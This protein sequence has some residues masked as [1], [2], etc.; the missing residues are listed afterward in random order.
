MKNHW[1][2]AI[3]LLS[4]PA[5]Q[6]PAADVLRFD[7]GTDRSELREGFTRVTARSVYDKAAGF[8]WKSA[9]GLQEQ[10]RHYDREWQ[11]DESRGRQ[12][13]PQIYT[14]EITCD[15]IVGRAANSFLIDLPPGDYTAW[16]LSGLSAGSSREYHDF[17]V[18]VDC[19]GRSQRPGQ[20]DGEN[21][22][23][24]KILGPYI[25]EKRTFQVSPQDG[26][27]SIEFQP[28]TDWM[29][30]AVIVFPNAQAEHV[31][32]DFLDAL[33][34]EIDF[35]PPDVAAQWHETE[36]V[37]PR[38]LPEF[39]PADRRRGYALFARHWSEVIYPGTVPRQSELDPR[40][41]AFA[42]LGEYE[43]VTF[44]VHPLEDLSGVTVTAGEL[45]SGDA[46]IP[47]QSVD[48][49]SVR[50]MLV[51]PNYSTYFSYHVAPDVLE[52]R[53]RQDVKQGRNQ[54][55]WITV[56]VPDDAAPGVYEGKL[57]LSAAGREPAEVPLS[58]RVLPVRLR[59]NP[60]HIYG[61]YY[62]D[63]LSNL[64]E[65][66]TPQANEY[67][68]RKAELERRDMVEHGMTCH[69]SGISG[70][71]RDADGRWTM[72]GE[73]TERRIALDRRFGLADQPLV[74]S[75][76]VGTWYARLVDKQGLGSHLRLV[77]GDVPQS[78][79]DEVTGMV[80]AIEK[81][82]SRR[83]WPEFL[84]YPIDEPATDENPVRF[85]TG[86]LKAV[87]RVP[88]VRTYVTADPSH[89]AF[90]PMW[91]WV[92]VWCCQPFVF[93]VE[94]IRRLSREKNI[95][96]WCY[97][98]H[99]SGEN[100]HTPVRGVRMTWG[101]G[102]WKSGFKTLIPW[103]YQSSGG[104]PWNYLDGTSM[105]FFNRSTPDGEPIPVAMWEA[106]REGIDDGRYLYTLQQLVAEAKAAGGPAAE[107]AEAARREL[108]F[109]WNAIEV[110]EK[111]K[112][113]GLWSG[114]DFDAYRWL[115]ASKILELEAALS[116]GKDR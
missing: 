62:R 2:P 19:P 104:D 11:Y 75:F 58:I 21:R 33:E 74:V 107:K 57:T 4:L 70:L 80:E 1:L 53:D 16:L 37:D 56:K 108:D 91:P 83:G 68:R 73:E 20:L 89:E 102:F 50:Y 82:R 105:D 43:P 112:Y 110:Q 106:Y 5:A 67:F 48:V 64:D 59:K 98:N 49:R 9:E 51:R 28:R 44:T 47:A 65:R 54:R 34:K 18:A 72:D 71:D 45:R 94:K 38:P 36:H 86:V 109:V 29:A 22:S 46:A 10:Y 39:S 12:Q 116:E 97:P 101:F 60:E 25:F 61:M 100:D 40:L 35:L 42:S 6:A 55:F 99:I 114:P 87:K 17:D 76:P 63:P 26:R 92:D 85:M 113:D 69:I 14:N 30:A 8:G 115:L 78:F 52:H 77:R 90:E 93:G 84:Y 15:A 24:V 66:N 32:R 79:Y 88:G 13:P 96:F 23:T 3:V 81:E 27:L 95:E 7:M 41:Q 31:G 103:I 111:Y